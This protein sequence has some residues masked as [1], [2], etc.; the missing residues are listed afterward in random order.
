M[1]TGPARAPGRPRRRD[2]ARQRAGR[3]CRARR[4]GGGTVCR[5]RGA[6]RC[7]VARGRGWPALH[8]G[9]RRRLCPRTA[10]VAAPD[11]GALVMWRLLVFV[12]GLCLKAVADVVFARVQAAI[13]PTHLWFVRKPP[14][15]RVRA[16]D[17]ARET[18]TLAHIVA[19]LRDDGVVVEMSESVYEPE[20]RR[21]GG[22][23]AMELVHAFFH[24]DSRA[25]IAWHLLRA[26]A[27][28]APAVASLAIVSTLFDRLLAGA[29]T[30]KKN[31]WANLGAVHGGA[32]RDITARPLPAPSLAQLQAVVADHE[33]ELLADY[34]RGCQA[35]AD[36]IAW[37]RRESDFHVGLRAFAEGVAL[38]LWNRWGLSRVVCFVLCVGA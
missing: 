14:G 22:T 35:L 29:A 31:T 18:E 21:F 5:R 25:F 9:A 8:R 3:V 34:D 37:L 2:P 24:V 32:H 20:A 30:E 4:C 33:A 28:L 16:R 19:G 7:G 15:L 10:R 38:F 6:R 17:V 13:E 36:G 27:R 12:F 26:Q 11:R 1:A 23:R